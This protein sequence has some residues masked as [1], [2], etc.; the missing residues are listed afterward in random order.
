[1]AHAVKKKKKKS[2]AEESCQHNVCDHII[3]ISG[4][5]PIPVLNIKE[6]RQEEINLRENEKVS[7]CLMMTFCTHKWDICSKPLSW[8][9]VG[10]I[11]F[12]IKVT[13]FYVV[14]R[15]ILIPEIPWEGAGGRLTVIPMLS[16]VQ[17]VKLCV[18]VCVC[19]CEREGLGASCKWKM[20]RSLQK[21]SPLLCWWQVNSHSIWDC[22]HCG[23]VY[24]LF[25]S[26]VGG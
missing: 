21:S 16:L 3:N 13:F 23:T 2:V 22:H 4:G 25:T 8:Y 12:R 5:I 20:C 10:W 9:V 18:C 15:S 24:N 19:V 17:I 7:V 14:R 6:W 1:M 26:D 11:Y